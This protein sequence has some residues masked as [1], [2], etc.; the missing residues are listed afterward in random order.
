MRLVV[1]ANHFL[2]SSVRLTAATLRASASRPDLEVVAIVDAARLPPSR[3]RLPREAA[4]R[5]GR[6]L[7]DPFQ[8]PPFSYTPLLLTLP[9][10]AR[11]HRVP[12]LAPREK[13]VNDEGFVDRLATELRPDASL[14]LMVDQL[15]RPPLLAASG[16]A[17]NYHNAMLPSHRGFGG[18]E[19]A[20]YQGE[21]HSGFT[22]HR[23]I[24]GLDE[25]PILLPGSVEVAPGASAD[26]VERAK[27]ELACAEIDALLDAIAGR[28]PGSPQGDDGATFTKAEVAAIRAVGDGSGHSFAELERRLRAFGVLELT[29]GEATLPVTALRR[30]AGSALVSADGIHFEPTR[31]LHLRPS[32]FRFYRSAGLIWLG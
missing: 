25:G 19:Y 30:T 11:R 8:P 16:E 7:S 14:V 9:A 24:E 31:I 21:R 18:P 2:S 28:E 6:R 13:T 5:I 10:L 26:Q 15:F 23:M 20:I 29:R 1:F 32:L 3:A 22:F 27:T 4:L 17:V 12:L